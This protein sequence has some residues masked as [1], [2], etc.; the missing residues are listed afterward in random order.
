[1]A[2][3]FQI[4]AIETLQNFIIYSNFLIDF[5]IHS[6]IFKITFGDFKYKTWVR[7]A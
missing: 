4:K 3:S 7:K 1:M 5:K 2:R 6:F